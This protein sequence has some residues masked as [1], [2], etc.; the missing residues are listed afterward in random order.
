MSLS[1]SNN[2]FLSGVDIIIYTPSIILFLLLWWEPYL[3][4]GVSGVSVVISGQP[5]ISIIS[6]IGT[7]YDVCMYVVVV[8]LHHLTQMKKWTVLQYCFW[9]RGGRYVIINAVFITTFN[10][11]L[12]YLFKWLLWLLIVIIISRVSYY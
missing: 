1:R 11:A 10:F 2:V 8:I 9:E 7:G 5:I 4:F 3:G 6:I 12:L